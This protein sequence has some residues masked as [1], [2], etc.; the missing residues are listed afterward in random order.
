MSPAMATDVTQATME[1][2]RASKLPV[3]RVLLSAQ[4]KRPPRIL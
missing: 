1:Q 2:V 4:L 3:R